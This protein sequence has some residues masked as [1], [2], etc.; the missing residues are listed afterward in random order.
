MEWNAVEIYVY[1]GTVVHYMNGEKVMEYHLW[2]DEWN[3]MIANSKFPEFNPDWAN[4]AKEGY[5]SLQDHGHDTWF[6]NIKI[7]EL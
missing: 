3:E 6:R 4:V 7:R 5:I 2:T 1:E